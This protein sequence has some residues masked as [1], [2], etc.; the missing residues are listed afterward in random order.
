MKTEHIE[1]YVKSALECEDK[2][3]AHFIMDE[4]LLQLM[5]EH[6]PEGAEAWDKVF[7]AYGGFWYT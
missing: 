1:A 5:I 6:R 2:E 7:A 3:Q 4:M